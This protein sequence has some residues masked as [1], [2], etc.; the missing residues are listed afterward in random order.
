MQ[1]QKSQETSEQDGFNTENYSQMSM[2]VKAI[3]EANQNEYA[4]YSVMA[5]VINAEAAKMTD[6]QNRVAQANKFAEG[7][8]EGTEEWEGLFLMGLAIAGLEMIPLESN[9]EAKHYW[10]IV[11]SS[12]HNTWGESYLAPAQL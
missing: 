6:Y 1:T 2:S 7:R 8:K 5:M 3:L 4:S 11:G 10:K 9:I 12:E